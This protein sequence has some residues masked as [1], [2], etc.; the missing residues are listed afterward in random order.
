MAEIDQRCRA[1]GTRAYRMHVRNAARAYNRS[2]DLWRVDRVEAEVQALRPNTRA[3][4]AV[5]RCH[6]RSARRL[7]Q[8]EPK[9]ERARARLLRVRFSLLAEIWALRRAIRQEVAA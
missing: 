8:Q 9:N 6:L 4:V 1:S 2:A 3:L 5:L 7:V